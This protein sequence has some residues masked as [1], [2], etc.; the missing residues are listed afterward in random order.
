MPRGK[1]SRPPDGISAEHIEEQTGWSRHATRTS[2]L[3]LSAVVA[4]AL[5]GI[6]GAEASRHV[7]NAGVSAVLH[8]PVRIRNGEMF[9]MRLG[10]TSKRPIR[11]L[12]VGVDTTIWE[13]MTINSLVPSPGKESSENGE[14]RF[15]FGPLAAA[16]NFLMKVDGQLNPDISGTNAGTIRI[17]DGEQLLAE[18]PAEIGVLP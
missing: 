5:T 8:A 15:E 10:I 6:F 9:E 13:D 1:T 3:V 18:L 17:Y 4:A 7:E 11:S 14:F 2:L 12:V 16:T